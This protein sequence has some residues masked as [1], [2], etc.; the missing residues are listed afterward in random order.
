VGATTVSRVPAAV[1]YTYPL[2]LMLGDSCGA[3]TRLLTSARTVAAG[4]VAGSQ[5]A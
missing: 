2:I 1:L 4:S 3:V 5:D